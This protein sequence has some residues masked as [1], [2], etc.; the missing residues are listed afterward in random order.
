[1]REEEWRGGG[2]WAWGEAGWVGRTAAPTQLPTLPTPGP[3]LALARPWSWPQPSSPLALELIPERNPDFIEDAARA[4]A[5]YR[6]KKVIVYCGLGGTI[7]VGVKPWAPDRTKA[8]KD[9]PERMFG[10]ESRSLKAC[11]DLLVVGGL[12]DVAHL[13]GGLSVW[14]HDGLPTEGGA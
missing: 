1:M 10:R 9:D 7:E 14:R 4:L 11:H 13:E 5:P 3:R 8:F 6:G 2:W 12:R